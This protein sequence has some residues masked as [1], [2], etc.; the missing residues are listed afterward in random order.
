MPLHFDWMMQTFWWGALL[1]LAVSGTGDAAYYIGWVGVVATRVS[2][3]CIRLVKG[4]L[5]L[6]RV[7]RSDLA[8]KARS[9]DAVNKR[10]TTL[11]N[12]RSAST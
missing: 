11:R 8:A 9:V 12:R 4:W 2:G 1:A 7:T 10:Q 5:A 6:L 3:S